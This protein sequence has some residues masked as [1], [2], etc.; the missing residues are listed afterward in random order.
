MVADL[1][2]EREA[3]IEALRIEALR[4]V[5]HALCDLRLVPHNDL[6]TLRLK[7]HLREKIAKLESESCSGLWERV[8]ARV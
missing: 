8:A 2:F 6:H 5:L 4:D 7:R 3:L 1:Q